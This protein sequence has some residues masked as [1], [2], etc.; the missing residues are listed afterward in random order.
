MSDLTQLLSTVAQAANQAGR[1]AQLNRKPG[2]ITLKP[3]GSIVTT[4]D[5]E[6]EIYLRKVLTEAL[7]G[8]TVWGEELGYEEPGP[9]GLWLVD[10][11]DG[12]TNFAFG[13]PLWGVSIGLLQGNSMVL[14][15]IEL[16]DLGKTYQ[17]VKG[18]GAFR[19]G[20]PLPKVNAE[21]LKRFHPVGLPEPGEPCWEHIEGKM[22]HF[23]AWVI[24]ACWFL[25][26]WNRGAF[27]SR[28]SLYDVAASIVLTEE[29]GGFAL[30]GTGEPIHY[31]AILGKRGLEKPFALVPHPSF[32]GSS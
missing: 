9:N 20:V 7:P 30:Y 17:A 32:I 3:D 23:G 29:V 5:R 11:V 21:P 25:E 1:I 15:V 8:S 12:T 2:D 19:N 4:A 18:G 16:P 28:G 10:P 24:E 22:R 26:G 14:G 6:A 13:S 27:G 31:P